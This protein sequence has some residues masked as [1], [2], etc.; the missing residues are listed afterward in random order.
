MALVN[1]LGEL[2]LEETQLDTQQLLLEILLQL[3][4]VNIHLSKLSDERVSRDDLQGDLDND[5]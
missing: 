3:R 4:V 2:G 1:I 5:Y